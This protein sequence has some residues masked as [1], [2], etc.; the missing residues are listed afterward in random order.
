MEVTHQVEIGV[1]GLF[2]RQREAPNLVALRFVVVSKPGAE[3]FKQVRLGHHHVN[4]EADTQLFMQLRQPLAQVDRLLARRL[5]G[6]RQ[7]IGNADGD[8]DAVDRLAAAILTQQADKFQPLSGILNLLALLGGVAPR[9]VQQDSFVREPPVAVA[10]AA[11][12]AQSGFTEA[13]R[14]RELQAGIDQRRGFTGARCADNDVP[15]Q[16][17][18]ILRTEALRP[19]GTVSRFAEVG[20]FQHLR[21]FI[22]TSGEDLLLAVQ[23]LLGIGRVRFGGIFIELVHQ[24][25][26]QPG[27][28]QPRQNMPL[29]PEQINH[30][31]TDDAVLFRFERAGIHDG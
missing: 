2:P 16:L 6:E 21:R 28:V 12:A 13:I 27:V 17:V 1:F 24:L 3:A 4:R 19:L 29:R 25:A 26:V 31:N 5:R 15:R 8:N 30:R 18:E 11:N 10:R 14:Q 20:F 23:P 7:Q 22:K 9:G